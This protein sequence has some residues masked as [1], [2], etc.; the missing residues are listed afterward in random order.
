MIKL[1]DANA[2]MLRVIAARVAPAQGKAL[3]EHMRALHRATTEDWGAVQHQ[4]REVRS[5]ADQL[6]PLLSEHN[7]G[8]DDMLALAEA[9]VEVGVTRDDVEYAGAEQ[10][11]MA[12]SAIVSALGHVDEERGK[13]LNRALNGLYESLAKD[14]TYRPEAYVASLRDFQKVLL[15]K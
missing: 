14:E 6:A 12:L 11:A 5:I 15:G 1:Y 2:V 13:T 9:L 7:F 8:R 4:A 3:A 10:T